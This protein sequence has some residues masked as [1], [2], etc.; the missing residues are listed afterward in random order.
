MHLP[1]PCLFGFLRCVSAPSRSCPAESAGSLLATHERMLT[2]G[3][4]SSDWLRPVTRG[5]VWIAGSV[6]ALLLIWTNILLFLLCCALLELCFCMS[7][8]CPT[9]RICSTV[10]SCRASRTTLTNYTFSIKCAKRLVPMASDDR[11][12]MLPSNDMC[13][14]LKVPG[15]LNI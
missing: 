2:G 3:L 15:P 5:R 8:T 12:C 14:N 7:W 4:V 9:D 11:Y 10:L 1:L 13:R 6:I